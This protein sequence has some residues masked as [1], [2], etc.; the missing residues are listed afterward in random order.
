MKYLFAFGSLDTP[1]ET[2]FYYGTKASVRK[3]LRK[4]GV[5]PTE[6]DEWMAKAFI[7]TEV[8][9]KCAGLN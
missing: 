6:I 5:E 1:W 4:E 3:W 8:R 2:W 7:F 9:N